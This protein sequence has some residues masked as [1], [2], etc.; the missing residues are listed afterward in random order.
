MNT[1][2]NLKQQASKARQYLA[3]LDANRT[4]FQRKLDKYKYEIIKLIY[5]KRINEHQYF[6]FI[7]GSVRGLK[8]LDALLLRTLEGLFEQLSWAPTSRDCKTYLYTFNRRS[9]EEEIRIYQYIETNFLNAEL[10]PT[11]NEDTINSYRNGVISLQ[12]YLNSIKAKEI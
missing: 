2:Q 9:N 4:D 3:K 6:R 10:I 7:N 5:A 8:I 12:D 11:T 1:S